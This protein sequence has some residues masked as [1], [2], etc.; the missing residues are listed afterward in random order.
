MADQAIAGKDLS[1]QQ[2]IDLLIP[3]LFGP[4]PVHP[5]DLPA[6]PSLTRMLGRADGRSSPGSDPVSV[7]LGCFGI[8]PTPGQELPSAPFSRLADL[9]EAES[10]G[11]VMHADP[12]HL[13]PDR[14]RLL[15]FDAHHLALGR[16]ESDA[17]VDL[18]NE[19][20]ARDGL[21]LEAVSPQRWY[22]HV[23]RPPRLRTVPLYSAIGRSIS[24][25]LPE[26]EDAT[27]W[28][29]FL[30]EA[31]MLFHHAQ[32]NR[33]REHE[34]CPTVSGIWPWGGGRLPAS[35]PASRYGHVYAAD[36]LALGLAA[37]TNVPSGS[38][39]EDATALIE[40]AARGSVL[41]F[42]DG[43]L[44]PVLDA[45]GAGWVEQIGRLERWMASLLAD[46][47]Q[48]GEARIRIYPCNGECFEI[49]AWGLRRFWRRPFALG[50][51]LGRANRA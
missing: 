14:D 43:L 44:R 49:G 19:H 22:L 7:L 41:M 28:A 34:G 29:R 45:D 50:A 47:K 38:V 2:R 33:V 9:P 3:G 5:N 17:L 32:S 15:L 21:R 4:V 51:C 25:L 37:A 42:W 10:A 40:S 18:F 1:L 20:F 11:Y 13:R 12:V 16:E 23:E 26:G 39:P 24:K 30:N 46:R 6:T 27:A 35:L 8:E 31:Q 36:A 48:L